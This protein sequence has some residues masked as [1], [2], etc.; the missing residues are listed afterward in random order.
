MLRLSK[1]LSA[2]GT[3]VFEVLL[4]EEI[5][6]LDVEVLPL[7]RGLSQGSYTDGAGLS[8]M[9]ISIAEEPNVI[10]A[11]AGIFYTAIIAGCRS[12]NCRYRSMLCR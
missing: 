11:K 1:S 6:R 9:I 7:Q 4:K 5:E 8:V 2:W 3:P 10:R 12:N